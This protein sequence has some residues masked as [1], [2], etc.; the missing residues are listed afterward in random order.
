M[1]GWLQ[2]RVRGAA[3]LTRRGRASREL[4]VFLLVYAVYRVGYGVTAGS[5][6]IA[7]HNGEQLLAMERTLRI[8][9]EV[10]LEHALHPVVRLMVAVYLAAQ[11]LVIW[12]ILMSSWRRS[13]LVYHRLKLS[14]IGAATL[15]AGCF[16][17]WPSAPPRFTP[18]S[19]AA[20]ALSIVLDQSASTTATALY[21]PW[22]AIPS[23]H[24]AFALLGGL[25]L[26]RIGGPTRRLI[27]VVW[28]VL[29]GVATVATGNHWV[30]DVAA[31]WALGYVCWRVAVMAVVAERVDAREVRAQAQV[32][33]GA[34]PAA[35]SQR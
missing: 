27:A 6:G 4:L 32:A 20:D 8:D 13:R 19:G 30:I 33:G 15:A 25:A 9:W 29:V 12:L 16:A 10:W 1:A 22:A 21:N 5:A 24:C 23:L 35:A 28:P 14:V 26:W 7:R 17:L 2:S 31:G 3:D 18:G 11:L 34:L